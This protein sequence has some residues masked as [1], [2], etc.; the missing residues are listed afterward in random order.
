MAVPLV[1]AILTDMKCCSAHPLLLCWLLH[2]AAFPHLNLM[3]ELMEVVVAAGGCE[4]DL[5]AD[6]F[7]LLADALGR[8]TVALTEV[9]RDFMV[10][11]TKKDTIEKAVWKGWQGPLQPF[12]VQTVNNK[13]KGSPTAGKLFY[14][15]QCPVL[16]L[17]YLLDLLQQGACMLDRLHVA[18]TQCWEHQWLFL[19]QNAKEGQE[20]QKL[21]QD[22]VSAAGADA[23]GLGA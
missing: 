8:R 13:A 7:A 5:S 2:R 15:F 21:A 14:L 6:F 19:P 23:A 16:G 1:Q 20:Q 18:V 11:W 22:V 10:A 3:C 9:L 4:K 12:V 17:S